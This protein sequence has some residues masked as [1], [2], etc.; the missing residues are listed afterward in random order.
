MIK[1]ESEI[2]RAHPDFEKIE[3]SSFGRVRSVKGHYYTGFIDKDGYIIVGFRMNGKRVS[4]KVHRLVAQ[5][6]LPNPNNFPQI[7][8]L[9][10]NRKNNNVDNLEWCDASYNQQYREKYGVS[11]TEALGHSVFAINL[12]AL[13]VSHFSS[14]NEASRVLGVSQ[15]NINM[16][17]KGSR[18]QTGGFWFVNDD[19]H[20]VEAVKSKL[21]D[22]G[23]TGLKIK[24]RSTLKKICNLTLQANEL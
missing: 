11:N 8:H 24:H 16:V 6:F 22:V 3:V 18:N 12:T 2:W 19:G 1:I 17:I 10:C 21:H 7:N 20:A 14:Q 23:G 13:E 9:D 5:T 4:K 15:G